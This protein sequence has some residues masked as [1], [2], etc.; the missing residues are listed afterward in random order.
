MLFSTYRIIR[1]DPVGPLARVIEKTSTEGLRLYQHVYDRLLVL[2]DLQIVL[3]GSLLMNVE[4]LVLL[5][6]LDGCIEDISLDVRADSS[7]SP[8]YKYQCYYHHWSFEA[9]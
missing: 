5:T 3:L 9:T 1:V 8:I 6:G 7:I 4:Q 2:R